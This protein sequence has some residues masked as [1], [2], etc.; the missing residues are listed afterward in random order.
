MARIITVFWRDIPTQ[1]IAE[2]GTGRNRKQIKLELSKRFMISVDSSAMMAN[3]QD[4]EEYLQYWRKSEPKI[5]GIDLE[6]EANLLKEN[7]EESYDNF[8]LKELV[9]N[10]GYERK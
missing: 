10:G 7:I 2:D 6:K 8:R 1:I 9:K 4:S 3:C 5:I